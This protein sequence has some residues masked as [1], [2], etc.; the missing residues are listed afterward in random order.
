MAS[1]EQGAAVES[2]LGQQKLPKCENAMKIG[3]TIFLAILSCGGTGCSEKQSDKAGTKPLA[4]ESTVNAKDFAHIKIKVRDE[5]KVDVKLL[6]VTR[7]SDST[8]FRVKM[9]NRWDKPITQATLSYSI[10]S[11]TGK[12]LASPIGTVVGLRPGKSA[13]DATRADVKIDE[14]HTIVFWTENEY[15]EPEE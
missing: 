3:P 14:V 9:T 6:G 4:D 7:L 5:S 2:A 8:E 15:S 13:E 10:L 1:I 11:K 12:E